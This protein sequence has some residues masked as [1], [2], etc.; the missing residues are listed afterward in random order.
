[1][2]KYKVIAHRRVHKFIIGLRNEKLK[3]SITDIIEKL[4]NYPISLKEMDVEKIKGFEK[5]FRIRIGQYRIIFH[6]DKNEKTIYVT[7]LDARKRVY[8]K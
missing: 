4:E 5:T 1:V 6:V 3:H 8:K 2:P 7:H